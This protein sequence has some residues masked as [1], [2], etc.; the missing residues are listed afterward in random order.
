MTLAHQHARWSIAALTECTEKNSITLEFNNY[1]GF[2]SYLT[3]NC[4]TSPTTYINWKC[5][6]SKKGFCPD[7]QQNWND[8]RLPFSSLSNHDVNVKF[9]HFEK[10]IPPKME[11]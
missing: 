6:P 1:D 10:D 9:T 5:T 2:F 3:K 8:L 7:I 4:Q 11:L